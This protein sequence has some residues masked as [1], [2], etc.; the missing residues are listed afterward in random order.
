MA[1]RVPC[2]RSAILRFLVMSSYGQLGRSRH[3]LMCKLDAVKGILAGER[4]PRC[5]LWYGLAFESQGEVVLSGES[6][7]KG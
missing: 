5:R 3:D 4:G 1:V 7:S 2:L 6:A